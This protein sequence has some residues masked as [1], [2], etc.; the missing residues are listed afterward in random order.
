MSKITHDWDRTSRTEEDV[1]ILRKKRGK[2]TVDEIECYLRDNIRSDASFCL[3]FEMRESNS[4]IQGVWERAE[5][6]ITL[7]EMKVKEGDNQ[8]PFNGE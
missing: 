8:D 4:E 3:F 5:T 2:F 6:S 1:L 7:Y